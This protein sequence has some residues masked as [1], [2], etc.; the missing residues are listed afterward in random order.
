M[1]GKLTKAIDKKHTDAQPGLFFSEPDHSDLSDLSDESG[2]K[3]KSAAEIEANNRAACLQPFF[4]KKHHATTLHYDFR[5]G[6]NGVLVSWAI[7]IGP[8][9]YPGHRR[10][11]KQVDDHRKEYGGFEGVFPQGTP[12]AGPTILWD[13]GMWKPLPGYLDVDES[14]RKGCLR[15]T[16]DGKKLKGDWTLIWREGNKESGLNSRWYLIKEA[17]SFARS[18]GAKSILEEAPNSVISGRSLEY[19]VR[20]WTEGNGRREAGAT[21]FETE[22]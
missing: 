3:Q 10:K 2:S 5:L 22:E 8:S 11:A 13:S 9:L 17:D 20:E 15:F 4:I 14:L 6:H 16:L 18:E 1:T 19:V 21:L 12:G 7:E